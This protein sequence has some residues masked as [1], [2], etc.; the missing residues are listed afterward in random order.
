MARNWRCASPQPGEWMKGKLVGSGSFGVVHLA[1]NKATGA[2]FVVKSAQSEAGLRSLENEANILESLNSPHIVHCIGRESNGAN[3]GKE[4]NLFLEYVAGGSLSDVA[5]KFGGALDERVIRLYTREILL[6]L[7]HLHK[8]GI[9]HCDLK[10]KNV[11]LGS[12]GDVKL[13]DFGCAKRLNCSKTNGGSMQ[14][15]KSFAGTPLWM[16]PEVL[17]NEGFDFAADIWSLGC[18]VIEM[19]TSRPPWGDEALNPMAFMMKI[20]RSNEIPQFPHEFSKE[21]LDFLA[22]CLERNPKKRWKTEEL[23]NHPFILGTL[24]RGS[25][26]KEEW[27]CSPASILDVGICEEGYESDESVGGEFRKRIPFSS[28][29][30]E[31][32]KSIMPWKHQP[33]SDFLLSGNWITVRSG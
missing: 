30:C 12:S 13:A 15:S 18:T 27:A 1:M 5:E 25:F 28:R 7:K 31:E 2:L 19:A 29:C 21:G 10:C 24:E 16:A 20:A 3:G 17:R 9:V 6:G 14:S 33:E 22:K 8:N 32:R 11:L 4:F 26:K 23:L